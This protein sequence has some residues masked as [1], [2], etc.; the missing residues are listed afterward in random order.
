MTMGQWNCMDFNSAAIQFLQPIM[1]MA[2]LHM[3]T[4]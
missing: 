1:T 3:L 2:R 4:G